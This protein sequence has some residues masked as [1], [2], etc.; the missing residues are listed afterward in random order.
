M[1]IG[2][3]QTGHAPQEVAART[4]DYD[5][6]FQQMLGGNGFEFAVWAVVDGA[7]PESADAADGWIIT[8]SRHGAY[9]DHPWIPRL[10][11]LIRDIHA[12]GAPL[13]GICFGHQIIAQAL[14]GK[15]EKFDGGW[16]V[17]ATEYKMDGKTL[18]LNAW[19]QDQVTRLPEGA[20]V[21]ASNAFC[22]NAIVAYGDNIWTV[23]PHPE[24]DA[25]FIK[26]LIDHRGRGV[27]PDSQLDAALN[28]LDTPTSSAEIVEHITSFLKKERA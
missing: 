13:V 24:Y 14:G 10:E 18:T 15:V 20:R 16:S 28:R 8:G 17:G 2:I 22:K 1:K 5:H 21:L 11:Q 25:D 12:R 3:L 26:G 19:H 27:V 7:F 9:E 4:G 6:I 23:Q